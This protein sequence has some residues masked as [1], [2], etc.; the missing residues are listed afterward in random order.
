MSQDGL[1]RLERLTIRVAR[2]VAVLGLFALLALAVL[3]LANA[4]MRWLFAAPI[5]GVRD[6]V[7]L[8][9]AVAIGSCLPATLA[10][11]Q[12]VT[13]RFVGHMLQTRGRNGL[14]LFGALATLIMFGVLAW[15]LQVWTL[16]LRSLGDTTENIGMKI[17]PWWQGV[18]VLFYFTVVVQI[19]VAVRIAAALIR[20]E[21]VDAADR[22]AADPQPSEG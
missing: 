6:W 9:V 14:E 3:I 19:L 12:N 7:K 15:Q 16:E 21:E 20:G 17:W 13:I 1:Y 10:L 18:T 2:V 4:T 11:R 22:A 5:E 8:V